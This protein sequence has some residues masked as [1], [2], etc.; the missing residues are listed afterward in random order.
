MHF[1]D[2]FLRDD[3]CDRG[4]MMTDAAVRILDEHG[5]SGL[6]VSAVA[7][8]I[9]LTPQALTLRFGGSRGARY[10]VLQLAT[11]SF[12]R[13]WEGWISEALLAPVPVPPLPLRPETVRG[14]RVWL[15][16]HELAWSEANRGNDDL[17]DAIAYA[18]S[19]EREMTHRRLERW[20]GGR[21]PETAVDRI[22]ALTS[23]LRLDLVAP[24]STLDASIATEMLR[25]ELDRAAGAVAGW[26]HAGPSTQLAYM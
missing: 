17:G 8:H 22:S 19:N 20:A 9:G 15:A 14:V 26:P 21:L 2:P 6:T 1:S 13:R 5:A 3:S 7:R 23:G 12:C 4:D 11:V 24:G 16:L 10:R 25:R 18:R